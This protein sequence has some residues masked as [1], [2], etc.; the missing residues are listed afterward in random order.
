[1][2]NTDSS[3]RAVSPGQS[4]TPEPE[5]GPALRAVAGAIARLSRLYLISLAGWLRRAGSIGWD[6]I[7]RAIGVVAALSALIVGALAARRRLPPRPVRSRRYSPPIRQS[8]L[9]P[10]LRGMFWA[11]TA[12]LLGLV[13]FLGYCAYTLPLSG[14]LAAQLPPAAI[15]F[16]D[17]ADK[18]FAARG[19]FKG[20][21]IAADRLPGDLV[22]A[23]V[24]I[25]DRRFFEHPGIDLWGIARAAVRD[26]VSGAARQGASTITQQL[27]RLSYLSSERTLRRKVQEAMLAI[28]LEARLSKREILA[29]YL[30]TAYFGAG[31]Y[32]ADAAAKRYFGKDVQSLDL[33]E[34]A[35]LAGLIRAPSALA[36]TTNPEAAR[37]REDTVLHAMVEAGLIDAHQAAAARDHPVALAVPP[38]TEPGSNYFIDAAETEVKQLLGGPLSDLSVRTTLDPALQSAAER[39]VGHW[40]AT[41]GKKRHVGQAA[42]VAL[43]PD[44]AVLAMVGGRDYNDSQFNRATQAHRQPGSLFKIFVYLAA[45]N[46]GFT[47]DSMLVD[48]PVEIGDW[49]PKN[50][51]GRFQGP[52]SLRTAFAQSINSISVQLVDQ[53]GVQRVIDMAKSL[54]VKSELPAVPSLALGTA[55]VTL[56]EMTAAMDAIAVNSKSVTPYT[57][58]SMRAHGKTPLYTHG[59]VQTETPAW[60]RLAMMNILQAVVT[61]GTG[62][63]ARLDRPVAGKTG[64]A[65]DY[66]DAWFVGFTTDFVV[67]VWTGNDDDSPMQQV[68]GG[69]LPAK[70][71]HDFVQQ[72]EK[73]KS[74]PGPAP[75]AMSAGTSAAPAAEPQ[76]PGL[77]AAP[78]SAGA[79]VEGVPLVIDTAT[80]MFKGQLVHLLG[81]QGEGGQ[82]ARDMARYIGGRPVSCKS[83]TGAATQYRCRVG[84][85]DLAE[86]VLYNGGGR[87]TADASPPLRSAEEKARLAE[88]GVWEQ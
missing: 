53:I 85:S 48:Q 11:G 50:Y 45:F 37:Q 16:A 88:R 68:V 13:A 78:V 33:P 64:T 27:A 4:N 77:P 15:V 42:L 22:N 51:S 47:P 34:A 65:Q 59:E 81:V 17:D 80:L 86:A 9:R 76:Q 57:V 6:A 19:V 69:D 38:E 3:P 54:G 83:A 2:N 31:A 12:S 62:K 28:W 10:L 67:G 39:V 55:D 61:E 75:A 23:V 84:D 36:P 35:M 26:L 20:E 60:N 44:G 49:E 41:D 40:L 63:A 8:R 25:E 74:R 79:A 21:R 87:A 71:W 52:V 70:I 72:A 66:R 58:Q 1:V 24:A 82:F 32:G 30:N 5:L 56:I 46:A 14:G 29:R 18:A 43:A 7:E 73:I